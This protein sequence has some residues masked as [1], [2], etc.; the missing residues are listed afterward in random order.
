MSPVNLKSVSDPIREISVSVMVRIHWDQINPRASADKSEIPNPTAK[1]KIQFSEQIT[2][3]MRTIVHI[4][5]Y[6]LNILHPAGEPHTFFS[7]LDL[8]RFF[9]SAP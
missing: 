9:F 5:C 7:L 6:P 8:L 2:K 1:V 4:H 3:I